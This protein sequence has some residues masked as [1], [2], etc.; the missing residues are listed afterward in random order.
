MA[1]L[2][3]HG[4][5][6]DNTIDFSD[7]NTKFLEKIDKSEGEHLKDYYNNMIKSGKLRPAKK[8]N[9]TINGYSTSGKKDF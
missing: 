5:A 4:Y 3:V 8:G 2:S 1:F 9:T 6:G 7:E